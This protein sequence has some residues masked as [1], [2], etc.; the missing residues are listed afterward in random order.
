MQGSAGLVKVQVPPEGWE[1]FSWA[2]WRD[3]GFSWRSHPDVLTT[4]FFL[5]VFVFLNMN[6][7]IHIQVQD[8]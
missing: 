6:Y 5:F 1:G 4:C 2:V 8:L 7:K 3:A